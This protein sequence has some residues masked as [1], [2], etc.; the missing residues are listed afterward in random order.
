MNIRIVIVE[1][2][3]FIMSPKNVITPKNVSS[4]FLGK[5]EGE[6]SEE[7]G[8]ESEEDGEKSGEEGE[9]DDKVDED[10]VS[11]SSD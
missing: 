11:D 4:L 1:Q 5:E 6:E 10:E 9:E 8:E 7:E 3:A 2:R